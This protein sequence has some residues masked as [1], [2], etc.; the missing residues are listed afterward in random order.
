[1]AVVSAL[2]SGTCNTSEQTQSIYNSGITVNSLCLQKSTQA[3]ALWF[4]FR[5]LSAHRDL[6][7]YTEPAL[8]GSGRVDFKSA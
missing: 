6:H 7:A 4:Q 3:N 8:D 1:M 5:N 2:Y